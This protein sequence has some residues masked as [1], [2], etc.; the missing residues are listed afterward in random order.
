MS[1]IKAAII[2]DGVD[3]SQFSN[4]QSF[5]VKK[6][7]SIKKDFTAAKQYN[8]ATTCMKIM[9]KFTDI[10]NVDWYSIKILDD[11]SKLANIN[12]F[13]KALEL[14]AELGVKI[15]HL[16]IGT[17]IYDDFEYVEK[18]V[19]RLCDMGVI[20][21]AASSNK[22][23][24]TY[25]AYMNNVIG[26]KNNYLLKDDKYIFNENPMDHIDFSAASAHILRSGKE[27]NVTMRSN[28]YAAPIITAKVI[29][30]LNNN[31]SASFEKVYNLLMKNS[32]N[33]NCKVNTVYFDPLSC[34][35]RVLL[36]IVSDKDEEDFLPFSQ[37]NYPQ[38]I[39]HSETYKSE[40]NEIDLNRYDQII[41]SFLSLQYQKSEIISYFLNNYNG[42]IAVYHNDSFFEYSSKNRSE[43]ER[44]WLYKNKMFESLKADNEENKINIPVVGIHCESIQK[45]INIIYKLNYNFKSDGYY[46]ESFLEMSQA[47]LLGF[48]V[49]PNLNIKQFLCKSS[50]FFN[51]NIIIIGFSNLNLI[52]KFNDFDVIICQDKY[53]KELSLINND[54][55]YIDC[56]DDMYKKLISILE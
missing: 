49:I 53:K 1:R 17:S 8:H 25:P 33:K 2:D 42:K 34:A 9:K 15:I 44:L 38:Y 41:L 19:N 27:L 30:I 32:V 10:S 48:N 46:C 39:L 14:C 28:S 23:T 3:V 55:V 13:L 18:Y 36:N 26:V 51:C 22:G 43:A 12:Q 37:I 54:T 16:S 5:T 4:I 6:D 11:D 52:E 24:V 21:V 56:E 40:L 7:L 31:E 50:N 29:T 47:E 35:D 20:I 45:L